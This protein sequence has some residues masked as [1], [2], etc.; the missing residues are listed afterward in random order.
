MGFVVI[1]V[2]AW[3]AFFIFYSMNKSLSVLENSFIYLTVMVIGINIS[4]VVIEELKLIELTKE[5]WLYAAFFL[6]RSMIKPTIV[7]IMFNVIYKVKSTSITLLSI[8]ITMVIILALNGVLR[9]YDIWSYTRWNVFYDIL[10]IVVIQS[11]AF[12]LF[13]LYRR[14]THREVKAS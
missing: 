4:W 1:F 8:G 14:S 9:F 12:A 13:T 10:Q 11:I 6:Y 7:L 3:L 5:G 2:V